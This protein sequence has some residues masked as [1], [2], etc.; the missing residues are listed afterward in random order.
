VIIV[1][2]EHCDLEQQRT[3]SRQSRREQRHLEEQ[4]TA[5]MRRAERREHRRS[6]PGKR[7]QEP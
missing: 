2:S 4:D 1:A 6:G 3:V 7:K 5:G